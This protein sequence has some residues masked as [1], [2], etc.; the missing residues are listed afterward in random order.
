MKASLSIISV[1]L[2]ISACG[3]SGVPALTKESA[4][5]VFLDT[6][7]V[8]LPVTIKPDSGGPQTSL[9]DLEFAG[10]TV[11]EECRGLWSLEKAAWLTID[12]DPTSA[13]F[14]PEL[15]AVEFVSSQYSV[16]DDEPEMWTSFNQSLIVWSSA[17]QA[18]EFFDSIPGWIAECPSFGGTH[19]SPSS[20]DEYY[21]RYDNF[22]GSI[23][24][25]GDTIAWRQTLVMKRVYS[26]LG[27]RTSHS[28]FS[29]FYS[30]SIAG[31][32]I[33][34]TEANTKSQGSLISRSSGLKTVTENPRVVEDAELEASVERARAKFFS[35]FE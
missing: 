12:T 35:Q 10:Q 25:D 2:L 9:Y 15:R 32:N 30:A 31:A 34:V 24:D 27:E 14:P 23:E 29:G 33:L 13:A 6:S 21:A 22:Q 1:V 4:A 20:W 26:S 28:E 7:E 17:S 18:Q 11:P 16:Q 3:A 19:P 8:G 5:T